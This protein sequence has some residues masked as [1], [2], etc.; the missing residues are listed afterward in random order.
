MSNKELCEL[1][2]LL[3]LDFR[4]GMP[5]ARLIVQFVLGQD[6]S[7]FRIQRPEPSLILV[8]HFLQRTR[9]IHLYPD[10]IAVQSAQPIPVTEARV[11]RLDIERC[12]LSDRAVSGQHQ[13]C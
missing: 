3:N 4:V 12:K 13:M 9:I 10:G 7:V 5:P 1:Q 2:G 8:A 6:N 11:P